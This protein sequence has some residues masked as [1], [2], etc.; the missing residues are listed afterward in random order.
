MS[1][2]ENACARE[3]RFRPV[4]EK[5]ARQDGSR[6]MAASKAGPTKFEMLILDKS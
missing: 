4:S 6:A 1:I 3:S 2:A 5:W